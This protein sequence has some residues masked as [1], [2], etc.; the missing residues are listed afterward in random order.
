MDFDG[1][2]RDLLCFP[3]LCLLSW[4]VQFKYIKNRSSD[5]FFFCVSGMTHFLLAKVQSRVVAAKCSETRSVR[6]VQREGRDDQDPYGE[7]LS[8]YPIAYGSLEENIRSC[9][10]LSDSFKANKK[11]G[12][13]VS[14]SGQGRKDADGLASIC[15][16]KYSSGQLCLN[17][18][19]D[20]RCLVWFG[21]KQRLRILKWQKRLYLL[22]FCHWRCCPGRGFGKVSGL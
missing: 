4:N 7:V 11:T 12:T 13:G 16:N 2:L 20:K 15:S 14:S 5:R 17:P 19:I 21:L 1:N 6:S 10:R 18:G 22:G 8:L 9:F 3:I